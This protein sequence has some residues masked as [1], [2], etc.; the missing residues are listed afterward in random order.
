MKGEHVNFIVP[1]FGSRDILLNIFI[2]LYRMNKIIYITTLQNWRRWHT[3]RLK[4]ENL[5]GRRLKWWFMEKSDKGDGRNIWRNCLKSLFVH[6]FLLSPQPVSDGVV[7]LCKFHWLRC[8]ILIINTDKFLQRGRILIVRKSGCY[9]NLKQSERAAFCM[10]LDR[11]GFKLTIV[12]QFLFKFVLF[13]LLF[14]KRSRKLW[15][16]HL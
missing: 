15:D 3:M 7:C 6:P 16:L 11:T 5:Q 14:T 8:N 9:T 1:S 10:E 12:F 2:N 4:M 13:V